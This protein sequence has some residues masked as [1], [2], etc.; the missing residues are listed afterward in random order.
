M[1]ILDQTFQ[2]SVGDAG[3]RAAFCPTRNRNLESGVEIRKC[4]NLMSN[5]V[6]KGPRVIKIESFRNVKKEKKRNPNF[7]SLPFQSREVNG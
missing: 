7:R 2:S 3:N 5:V 6:S 4:S 1:L